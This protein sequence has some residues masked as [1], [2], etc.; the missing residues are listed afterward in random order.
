VPVV[1]VAGSI[2]P[3]LI[4][5]ALS[6]TSCGVVNSAGPVPS[7]LIKLQIFLVSI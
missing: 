7:G 5:N 2:M 1:V 6:V 3:Y 4:M